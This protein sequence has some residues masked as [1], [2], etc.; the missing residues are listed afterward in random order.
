MTSALL[1]VSVEK[2]VKFHRDEDGAMKK[3]KFFRM[4]VGV[5]G[6]LSLTLHTWRLRHIYMYVIKGTFSCIVIEV[7]KIIESSNNVSPEHVPT[8]T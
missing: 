3:K 1:A 5:V 2:Y 7:G 4:Q 8:V 6:T